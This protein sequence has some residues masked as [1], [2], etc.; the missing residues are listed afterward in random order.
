MFAR[1]LHRPALAIVISLLIL[2]MGGLA[3]VSLP[4]SQFPTV[5]PPSVIVSVSFPGASANVLVDSVLVILEQA[6]NGVQD[7]RYMTSAATS[8]GEATIQII[9][10]P[11]TDP[12]VAVLNVNNRIQMVKNRLPP[13]VEREGIVVLQNMSSM[14]M[15]V[16]VFSTDKNVD[17]N[18]LYNYTTVNILPEIKRTRGVGIA[19][20]LGNRAYAMRVELN[21]ERLRAYRLS[22]EDV[23]MAIAEQSMIGS[24]GRL[25][26]ATGRTSQTV[27]YVL[28]WVGRYDKP[29]QYENII[30]KSNPKGEILRL[31]DVATV[32]LGSSFYDLYSDIDGKPS[33]AIV[34]KQTPGSNATEVIEQVKKK[35][36]E[37]KEASFP[38]GM[39]YE[40]S[41]DV[42]NFLDASIEKVLHTLFEAFV[43]VSL[44]VYLFL[45]DFRSTLIPTLAVP[46]SL[47][48]TF[49]F[50]LMFGMS[51]NLITLF[52]LVLAIGV[53]VDDAIVVVEAVHEKMH[54]KHLGPYAAT[55]EVM[56]EISGAIIAITMVMTAVFI[57]VTF[58]PGPVG[59]F[60]RQF[61]LTMAMSIVLSGLVALT[62]TPV[63]CA[64]LLKP[65]DPHK[66]KSLNPLT[67]FLRLADKGIV[68]LMGGYARILRGLVT[69]RLLT[70]LV[71]AG[72][73]VGIFFANI[74]LPTGFIPLEDQGIIYGIIQTPPG[75]TL[76]YTNA[77]SHELA[78]IC[79]TLDEVVSVSSLAG[80]E[81]LTEGRG[82][83]AGTCIINLKNWSDRKLTSKQIIEELEEKGRAI[84]NVKLEFFEPPAV[85]G[86]G[87]AGGFS[88]N[89]LDKTNSGDYAKLGEVTDTFMTALSKRK[90]LKGLFTFFAANYPQYEIVI[91]NDVAMQKGVSIASA[92]N[93]LSI[94]V[95]S[96]WEQGFVRF[97]QFFKVYVQAAPEFRRY[98]EDLDNMFVKNDKGE[99]VP[100]S[101]FMKLK[102][103]QG[104]NEINRYNLYTTAAIQG[105]P[106]TGF[107]T[108]Q[109][110]AAIQ[111]V[112]A[113]TLPRGFDI[114][115]QGLSYD[116]ANKGN[117]ATYIFV[118]VVLFVYLVLVGQYESFLLPLAVIISL[119][120]G[121][122][123]SFLFLKAMGLA[124][125]V[126]AQIGLV[127]LV[128][129][130]GKNAI[131][132][133][134]FAVQRRHEGVSLKDAAIEGGKLRF[135][136]I[137]MT[138]FAFIAGLIPLVRAT[139]AGAIGNRTIGTT[140]V[141]GMLVGTVIGVFVI[142]GLYYI[143]GKMADGKKLI[144]DES[145]S[146]L[147]ELFEHESHGSH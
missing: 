23:M 17:Q 118:I 145:D 131:L 69:Q 64:M 6:I 21:L 25:G 65:I 94:V 32:E 47:I 34:L 50:M 38:P 44:V 116:E 141:G 75:S 91:D 48:G 1:I 135:R 45:G 14:L 133:I 106:A 54:D 36:E 97:G 62:L 53:V 104:L 31:R 105:A 74:V 128:G 13:I 57:P 147:S 139:G 35:L 138:S 84:S 59:V 82:S 9:F 134:E 119:P 5:A 101:A 15:Y 122:F 117:T 129:L 121:L 11:G 67:I 115:W 19:N 29:E 143:F 146:P 72:F 111:E 88:L 8:A 26:Q 77:K 78:E 18:F 40:V 60:Y 10:E 102:K 80:Y 86:F 87:A 79:R 132:I 56:H 3:I 20:I 22:P 41:Y 130:L 103:K 39:D 37:I 100:Y 63:L 46:V 95:G 71:I 58:I 4:I 127:M 83:N 110:I 43:L 73:C 61:G 51:I 27:E 89:L 90:E 113:E 123:G 81:V 76:E 109:A 68:K 2:F 92:M 96:T 66:K 140:A 49:F 28:T 52:A 144:K 7:M 70:M 125:D 107:S 85:P 99:M 30:L 136:P 120:V 142:P 55:K 33:A 24:P 16:N 12:N 112:A 93:N 114:G 124:N 126:Y 108:G 98:P 42:S 137:L